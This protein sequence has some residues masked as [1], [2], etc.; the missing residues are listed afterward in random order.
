MPDVVS[1]LVTAGPRRG[2]EFA[3]ADPAACVIGRGDD[4]AIRLP[5]DPA[6]EGVSRHHCLLEVRPPAA[7]ICDGG[8][9]NGTFVNGTLIGKRDPADPAKPL[10]YHDLADGDEVRLGEGHTTFR[11]QIRRDAGPVPEPTAADATPRPVAAPATVAGHADEWAALRPT[12]V[13]EPLRAAAAE[14]E[15]VVR[16]LLAAARTAALGSPEA[17]LAEWD[18]VRLLG[19]GGMGA[20]ALLRRQADGQRLALKVMQ[21]RVEATPRYRAWFRREVENTRAL[22]HPNVVRVWFAGCDRPPFFFALEYC[23]GGSVADYARQR[24]GK[25]LVGQAIDFVLQALTGLEYAHQAEVPFEET[26]GRGLVHRDL[27]PDNLFLTGPVAAP[28]VKVGDFGL[29]KAYQFAGYSGFTHS[30][31]VA[32]TAGFIPRQQAKDFKYVKPEADVWALAA[33][34]YHLL[35]GRTPRDFK[36]GP[37]PL[38][39]VLEQ[40]VV[41]LL[42]RDPALP[43]PLAAVIDEALIDT[44]DVRVK[45]ATELKHRLRDVRR[46]LGV[47]TGG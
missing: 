21:P 40:P 9:L 41:P 19:L 29:A 12:A 30:G 22:D 31:Q 38:V 25:L 27:K 5:N 11:V 42:A 26:T 23:P 46:G 8:S 10:P 24:G 44:P 39:A 15:G 2:Q 32:G 14:A 20:V 18:Y 4:C 34:L 6:H 43:G 28:V 13:G 7:R 36:P 45:T 3:F 33:T 47:P 16:T 1:L 35:T 37:H 17:A